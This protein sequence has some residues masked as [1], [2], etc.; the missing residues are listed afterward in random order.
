MQHEPGSPTRRAYWRL[1]KFAAYRGYTLYAE[2]RVPLDQARYRLINSQGELV[3]G[4]TRD[5]TEAEVTAYLIDKAT[6]RPRKTATT[7]G[8]TTTTSS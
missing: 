7:Q 2:R 3:I 1:R 8:R 6:T 5:V 4:Q